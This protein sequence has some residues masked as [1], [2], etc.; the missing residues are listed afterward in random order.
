MFRASLPGDD[1][2]TLSG[3]AAEISQQTGKT[4]P[5]H[6]SLA[7]EYAAA[8]V[9]AGLPEGLAGMIAEWDIAASQGALFDEGKPLSKLIGRPTTPLSQD[10]G[11]ALQ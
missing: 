11:Q 2:W 9:T 3:R 1:A 8:L 4:I 5:Y 10:V 7:A 6:D